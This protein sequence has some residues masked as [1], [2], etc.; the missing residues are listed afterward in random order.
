MDAIFCEQRYSVIEA[1][2]KSGKTHGCIVWI[3]EEALCLQPGQ[4]CWWVAPTHGQAKIA[5][6]RLKRTL[7]KY[8]YV[9]RKNDTDQL[10]EIYGRGAIAFRSGE[11]PDN[12]YGEDVYACVIDEA[13][14]LRE[15][16]WFAIRSTLTAT[17]GRVRIIGNVKGRKNWAYKLARKAESGEPEMHYAKITAKDAIE[18]GVLRE[19]E[20]EDARRQ[21]PQDIFNELYMA[22]PSDDEG[23]PFGLAAIRACIAPLSDAMPK[24]WGWDLARAVDWTV[25]IGLDSSCRTCRFERMQTDWEPTIARIKNATLAP[26]LVDSTGVGDRVFQELAKGSNGL[27]EGYKFSQTSKQ[28][29]MEGL[30]VAIQREEITF[31]EGP[32]LNELEMF[33][34][35][36]TRTGVHYSAP[37]G[38]HDDC[39]CALALA[40]ARYASMRQPLSWVAV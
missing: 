30:A 10:L 14:R 5:Y 33:E 19:E 34:Y 37:E 28:Q 23:N 29:L 1:S 26:A 16:A 32:I 17:R 9:F 36:Y 40:A 39:V 6:E 7:A 12:L 18:G 2:T 15:E 24:C 31:P 38:V 22:E 25:G 11:K 20:I 13:S 21:L 27:F 4:Y 35:Q 8:G 3:F